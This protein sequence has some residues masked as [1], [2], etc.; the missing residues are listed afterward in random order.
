M[1]E[2][3]NAYCR[4]HGEE[5][6]VTTADYVR[7]IYRSLARRVAEMLDVLKGFSPSPV[8]R[9]HVIGGGSRNGHLMQMIADDCGIP[10]VAGPAECTAL[11]NVLVQLRGCGR[12]DTLADMRR[13]A[14]NSTETKTYNPNI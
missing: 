3:I 12:A 11:G 1:V 7:V 9:L 6:P 10:V 2:A 13:I 14:V 4:A 8:K 5:V